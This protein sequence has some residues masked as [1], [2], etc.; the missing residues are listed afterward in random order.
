[1]LKAE[2]SVLVIE[3]VDDL[4]RIKVPLLVW[5]RA[6]VGAFVEVPDYLDSPDAAAGGFFRLEW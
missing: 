4:V 6:S 5:E 3:H 2:P 1:V